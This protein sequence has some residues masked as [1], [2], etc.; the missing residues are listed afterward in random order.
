MTSSKTSGFVNSYRRQKQIEDC[1]YANLLQRPYTSVSVSDL[2]HQMELSRKSFYN[3]FPDKD[4]CLRSVINRKFR[5]CSLA[6]A[7]G[8]GDDYSLEHVISIFL[9]YWKQERDFL[10]MILRNDLLTILFEQNMRFLM[11]EDRNVL[12]YLNTPQL[13]T[14]EFV[15]AAYV[16]IH[17]ATIL[18]W[19]KGGYAIPVEEMVR[20]YKRLLYE[21]LLSM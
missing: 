19:H 11:D 3:Y 16:N 8:L 4:S 7:D 9:K 17:I 14:D 10:D 18:Q 5:G 20:K 12:E 13:Q 6:I 21:P 2:C 15:L 1:L